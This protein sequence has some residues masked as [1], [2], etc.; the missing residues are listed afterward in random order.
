MVTSQYRAILQPLRGGSSLCGGLGAGR[1]LSVGVADAGPAPDQ[2]LGHEFPDHVTADLRDILL[3]E[4]N[5]GFPC[6][7]FG[8]LA[9]EDP[10]VDTAHLLWNSPDNLRVEDPGVVLAMELHGRVV[11]VRLDV[12]QDFIGS[13]LGEETVQIEQLA[14]FDAGVYQG[15]ASILFKRTFRSLLS[16]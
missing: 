5:A 1:W 16:L 4:T 12:A 8:E 9:S 10:A 13:S 15:W 7:V 3:G 6:N 2:A 11:H 14:G